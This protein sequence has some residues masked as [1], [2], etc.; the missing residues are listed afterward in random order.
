MRK[1]TSLWFLPPH[2]NLSLLYLQNNDSLSIVSLGFSFYIT[3]YQHSE[4][5][6]IPDPSR[7]EAGGSKEFFP[8][9]DPTYTSITDAYLKKQ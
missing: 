3:V 2:H 8:I 6:Y 9:A 4:K 1:W 7:L 5:V